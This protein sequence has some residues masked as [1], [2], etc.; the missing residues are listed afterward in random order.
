[1]SKLIIPGH[2]DVNKF[3]ALK[4]YK[5]K[6]IYILFSLCFCDIITVSHGKDIDK[7]IEAPVIEETKS[8]YLITTPLVI[9]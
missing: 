3:V 2:A 6:L 9:D 5:N 7:Q 4:F 8:K 1:V